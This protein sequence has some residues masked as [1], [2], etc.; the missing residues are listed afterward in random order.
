M[1][2]TVRVDSS[3]R[4]ELAQ[5]AQEL[6]GVSLDEAL[7]VVLFRYQTAKNVARLEADPVALAAYQ[8]EARGLAEVDVEVIEW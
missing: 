5:V 3:R 1:Q 6:G 8:A 7:R 4:D 2:T